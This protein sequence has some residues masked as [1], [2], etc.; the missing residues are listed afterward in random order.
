MRQSGAGQQAARGERRVHHSI[1]RACR[2]TATRRM[3]DWYCRV[4]MLGGVRLRARPPR[5]TTRPDARRSALDARAPC[6]SCAQTLSPRQRAGRV[7]SY[8]QGQPMA[9]WTGSGHFF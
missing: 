8:V 6:G 7:K 5:P 9:E 2:T 4:G 3:V 1:P